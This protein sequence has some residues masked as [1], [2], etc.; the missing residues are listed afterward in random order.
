VEGEDLS[1]KGEFS[2][3]PSEGLSWRAEEAINH[4]RYY[5]ADGHPVDRLGLR[6]LFKLS[7]EWLIHNHR[8]L[9]SQF[10]TKVP[11]R[12]YDEDVQEETWLAVIRCPAD[13]E[14]V[15]IV[16]LGGLKTCGKLVE[17]K[18]WAALDPDEDS[19][20]TFEDG[21]GRSYLFTGTPGTNGTR[22]VYVANGRN[23]QTPAEA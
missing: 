19:G 11:E 9:M 21:C 5:S 16:E 14:R 12:F 7:A 1:E 20:L 15:N 13:C 3:V 6:Q 18:D 2:R 10:T 17:T 23:A 22:H 4:G 8:P